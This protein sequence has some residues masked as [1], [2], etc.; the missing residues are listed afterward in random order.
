LKWLKKV[1][2]IHFW[3][4]ILPFIGWLIWGALGITNNLWYDEAY[5]AS[6]I[7]HSW[8]ELVRIT[9]VDDHSPF[10]YVLLKIF[11]H[12][13]GGGTHFFALKQM[14]VL[15]MAGYLFLGKYYVRKLF[16]EK[17]SVWFMFFSI[18]MP[19]MMVQ[20][21][22]VRMY[23][24]ALFFMT[25]AGLSAFDLY[26]EYNKESMPKE[27]TQQIGGDTGIKKRERIALR[28]KWWL[29]RLA[30]LACVYCHTFAMIQMFILYCLFF[31]AII[32]GKKRKMLK[33]YFV[34][35]VFVSLIFAP[36]LAVTIHQ[37]QL[38]IIIN[39]AVPG[40]GIPTIYTFMDYCKE[41]FSAL[42]TPIAPVVFAGMGLTIFLGYYAVDA[43]RRSKVYAPGLGVAAIGLTA[44]A[45][46]LISLYINPCFLGR[47]AFPGFGSLALLY[48]VGMAQLSSKKLKIGVAALALCCFFLQYRSEL[49][50]EYDGGLKTYQNFYRENVTEEDCIMAPNQHSVFLNVYHPDL[51]YFLYGYKLYSLPFKHTEAFTEWSQLEAIK[52]N[53]WFICFQGDEP[54]ELAE[55]YD[56]REVLS[57]H[58]MYYDFVIYQ[59]EKRDVT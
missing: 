25:L 39:P 35:G 59:L 46:T 8:F 4:I 24:V 40:S 28:K 13:F 18:T 52:G 11:Y 51:Q 9:A 26:R 22:N 38:R 21:G 23:A 30:S 16:G 7:S 20:A 6:M 19:I 31:G 56:Y 12:L 2:T 17:V 42:E 50:L 32:Y 48:G 44:L 3:W 5:S 27:Q 10:Y 57:F 41:W 49:S 34:S 45:G 53:K 29:F 58:Y 47:Y 15:F 55:L 1:K 37:M 36:W 54:D 33:P 43:M 14:S